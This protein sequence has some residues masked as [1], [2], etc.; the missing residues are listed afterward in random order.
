M[1]IEKFFSE[2]CLR[3]SGCFKWSVKYDIS[4]L[5]YT[6]DINCVCTRS[7]AF[8]NTV[9]EWSGVCCFNELCLLDLIMCVSVRTCYV[10]QWHD[11]ED[12]NTDGR[13]LVKIRNIL[14][15]VFWYVV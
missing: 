8:N 4:Y 1:G 6:R 5:W 12:L 14:V 3:K 10:Q 13:E 9:V 7:T 15:F 2:I 11:M